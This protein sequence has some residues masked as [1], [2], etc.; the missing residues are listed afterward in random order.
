VVITQPP[1]RA[2]E[3]T[4]KTIREYLGANIWH[5]ING[6]KKYECWTLW[7]ESVDGLT[8]RL[9]IEYPNGRLKAFH[10]QADEEFQRITNFLD[11]LVLVSERYV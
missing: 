7:L 1:N 8:K 4:M 3:L 11:E 9:E 2:K 6:T 5:C 10:K